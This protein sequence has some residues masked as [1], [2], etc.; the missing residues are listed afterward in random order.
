MLLGCV[1]HYTTS[2]VVLGGN[3]VKCALG[4]HSS[5]QF[6]ASYS[7]PTP[8][9]PKKRKKVRIEKEKERKERERE[10]EEG[11]GRGDI[12]KWPFFF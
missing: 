3:A 4:D 11:G 12:L 6:F 7:P 9:L 1:L 2:R 8:H 5:R 10:E